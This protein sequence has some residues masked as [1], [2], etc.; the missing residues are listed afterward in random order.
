MGRKLRNI[1]AHGGLVEVTSQ[2]IQGRFLLRPS[3]EVNDLILGIV[4]RAQRQYEVSIIYMVWMSNHFHLL[5]Y[6]RNA[7]Q[8]ADFM[9]DVKSQVAKE[10]G[11]LH[12]W[13][14]RF[15]GERYHAILVSEE[16]EAQVDRLRYCLSQGIKEGLV[17]RVEAW[18]GVQG[19]G[20]LLR[21]EA[22]TGTWFNR[23]EEYAAKRRGETF[24]KMKYAEKE[25]VVLSPLPC[26]QHLSQEKYRCE[27]RAL[28]EDIEK[29]GRLERADK[30][31]RPLGAKAVLAQNPRARSENFERRPA[32]AFHTFS[33]AVFEQL[34]EAYRLFETAFR[35]AAERLRDGDRE[36]EFP[37]GSFPPGLP[38]VAHSQ[39]AVLDS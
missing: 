28:I 32:P 13:R 17:N 5:L 30:G 2:V 23:S 7:K 39:I 1:P 8:L 19:V 4:G 11:P 10:I 21:G 22:M 16:P 20:N 31:S 35:T 6:V 25:K 27:V 36:V 26:W 37:E 15:W 38:F 24:E 34:R 3:A 14:D 18:P 9:R 29:Q 33:K 12:D